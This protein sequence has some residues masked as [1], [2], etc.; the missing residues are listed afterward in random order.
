ML[1]EYAVHLYGLELCTFAQSINEIYLWLVMPCILLFTAKM[2]VKSCFNKPELEQNDDIRP[3]KV[4]N[5]L[6]K[7]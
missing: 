6:Y 4:L 1:T 7:L 3:H 5:L 2:H